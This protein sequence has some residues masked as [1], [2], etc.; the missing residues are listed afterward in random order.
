LRT[1]LEQR[2]K[3]YRFIY[4]SLSE[5]PRI[6]VVDISQ[7]LKVYRNTARKRMREA[8]EQ[9]YVS[10][11][12]IR[13]RSYTNFKEYIYFLN[14]SN[15]FR[16]FSDCI[17]NEDIIY[18]AVLSGFANFWI[19]S[20][21]PLD[22]ED[23]ILN[24]VRSDYHISYAPDHSWDTSIKIVQKKI[25]TFDQETYAPQNIIQ[26]HWNE[27]CD[28]DS[29]FEILYR[30]FKYDL[31]EKLT[32]I[33]KKHLISTGKIYQFLEN[34]SA[35]CTVFTNYFPES[36]SSYDPYL[37]MFETDYEDFIIELFSQLPTSS[38]FFNVSGNVFLLAHVKKGYLRA[39]DFRN[40]IGELHI[41]F[42]VSNLIEKGIIKTEKHA[43][44]E[45]FWEKNL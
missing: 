1:T 40:D 34:L 3:Q 19:I 18:H 44:V 10:K 30:E 36:I 20:R 25:R 39:I 45:Y 15:P 12:Q 42:L 2:Q 37:Y 8:F 43:I 9:G 6:P 4:E 7:L 14:A 16:F 33:R 28:W 41:P 26:S 31:R 17:E 21:N 23:S 29:E 27:S 22:I 35:Y 5:S 13:K 32:P 38:W 11:P 24:G